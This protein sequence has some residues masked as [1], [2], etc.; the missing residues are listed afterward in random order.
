[1]NF[2]GKLDYGVFK[3]EKAFTFYKYGF[4]DTEGT[5]IS[6]N[7][8]DNIKEFKEGFAAVAKKIKVND[9]YIYKWGFISKEGTKIVAHI[10]DEVHD[11][12][13]SFAKVRI[14]EQC[15]QNAGNIHQDSYYQ[16]YVLSKHSDLEL[17]LNSSNSKK[18]ITSV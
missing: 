15:S 14:K 18:Y 7:I 10:F 2:S 5:V 17:M 8:F 13:N 1:M 16:K 12:E 4:V 3:E 11:F 9:K 6:E